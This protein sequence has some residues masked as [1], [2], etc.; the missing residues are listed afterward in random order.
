MKNKKIL[1]TGSTGYVGGRLVPELLNKG[2][3]VVVLVRSPAKLKGVSWSKAVQIVEGSAD[4]RESL[5]QALSG[6]D[7]A[8][9]LLH[10][11]GTK[12]FEEVEADMAK[13][14]ADVAK[15]SG[16]KQIIY[17]GGIANDTDLSKHLSSRLNV[18]KALRG[19]G[20]DV[21]ELRAGI[22]LG[23][24]SAS[25]EMLRYLTEHLPAMITPKWAKNKT[26]PIAIRDVLHYLGSA[27]D[28]D[29]PVNGVYDIVGPDT[30]TYIEMMQ[31]FAKVSGLPKRIIV[32]VP[33]LTPGLSSHWVGLVTPVP[34]Q[35]ARPLIGSLINEVVAKGD[36]NL[37]NI[38]PEPV[39]G[40]LGFED[41]VKK[42]IRTMAT[43]GAPTRWS[44]AGLLAEDL[45]ST[46]P[47]WAGG[48]KYSNTQKLTVN[49]DINNLWAAIEKIGGETGWYGF[50][51]A[52]KIRG[53]VDRLIGGVG[54]RR[55]RRDLN[56]LRVGDALDFWRVE[57]VE[58]G[59]KLVLRAE[60][61][62]PGIAYL[63]Y[64]LKNIKEG[65]AE[66][67]QK[68]TFYPKGLAGKAYWFSLLPV[69]AA[70]FPTM[71]KNIVEAGSK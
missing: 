48:S 19:T 49:C 5:E 45:H 55:G 67:E 65:V 51:W 16:V 4:S 61:R 50:D 53:G 59:T 32:P 56:T 23:S 13:L 66:V 52:W 63:E 30:L 15:K 2:H 60:M 57:V 64:S 18:G 40:L 11:L 44:D 58:R 21:L 24:G 31:R 62:L 37:R 7:L 17:L 68:A 29:K 28:L 36:N 41:A 3:D 6:V 35:I 25:F 39:G 22:I 27:S 38:L 20:V 70:L 1:V 8:Y 12:D 54:L 9:Y 42:S 34:S 14:F 71:L 26:Q 47:D 10:S 69:H 43:G 46:D 33:L